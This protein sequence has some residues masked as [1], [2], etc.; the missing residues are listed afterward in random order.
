M[1]LQ[2]GDLGLVI[3]LGDIRQGSALQRKT[4]GEWHDYVVDGEPLIYPF[5][6]EQLPPSE[7][8]LK[9]E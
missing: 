4:N 6:I 3:D 7:Y 2:A 8:R 1:M 5:D 9:S